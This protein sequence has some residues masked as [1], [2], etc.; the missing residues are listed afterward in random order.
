MIDIHSIPFELQG[1]AAIAKAAL[2]Y[3][4]NF[5]DLRF[6]LFVFI[7]LSLLLGMIIE[8]ISCHLNATQQDIKIKL[9]P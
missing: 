8:S 3:M 6:D 1:N 9:M 2:M 4:V 5:V 7:C